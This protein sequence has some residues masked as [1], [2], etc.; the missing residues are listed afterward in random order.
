[1][2]PERRKQIEESL[3]AAKVWAGNF[4]RVCCKGLEGPVIKSGG[5]VEREIAT[6]PVNSG[7]WLCEDFED[8]CRDMAQEATLYASFIADS[9]VYVQ[10]LLDEID[11]LKA[12]EKDGNTLLTGSGME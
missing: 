8:G 5:L 7:V 1:M 3:A 4:P 2:T 10:E 12:N 11:E 6:V 9:I